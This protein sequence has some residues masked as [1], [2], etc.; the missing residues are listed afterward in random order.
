[1]ISCPGINASYR[2]NDFF[3]V[4][5]VYCHLEKQPLILCP[6]QLTGLFCGL[7][8]VQVGLELELLTCNIVPSQLGKR[9]DKAWEMYLNV[10]YSLYFMKGL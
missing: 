1:M 6:H 9:V 10:Y 3:T 8:V 7:W 4:S 5:I 2:V